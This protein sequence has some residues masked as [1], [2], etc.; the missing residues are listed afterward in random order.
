M[1]T[2]EKHFDNTAVLTILIHGTEGSR[3]DWLE[4]DGYT[5]G[6]NLT[7]KLNSCGFSWLAC[8]LYGHGDYKADEPEFD[9]AYVSDELWPKFIDQSVESVKICLAT[10]LEK[11]DYKQ[12]HIV[13][14]SGGS[15]IA[16]KLL[17]QGL[18]LPVTKLVMAVPS[19]EKEYDDEYSFH[20]HLDLFAHKEIKFFWGRLDD[21]ISLEEAIWFY[22]RI[23]GESK[24]KSIYESGHDLPLKWVG[25]AVSF[26]KQ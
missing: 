5:K 22:D 25:E 16:L 15:Q 10:A 18:V 6:G 21:G 12:L 3:N 9:P 14:Y 26:L 2:L 7:E 8:D 23:P 20:N 13:T 19:P 17:Q 1:K 4:I 24:S 11:R